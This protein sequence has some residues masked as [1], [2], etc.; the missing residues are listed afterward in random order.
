M[1]LT[2]EALKDILLSYE[3]SEV[4]ELF[5]W[6]CY[7]S[8][9]LYQFYNDKPELEMPAPLMVF[10]ELDNWQGTSQRSG[11]WQYYE[12]RSFEDG[13][14]E[15]VTDYLR[16]L[17]ETELADTYASGIHDYSDPEYTK[18]GNYDYPDEWLADSENIDIWIDERNNDICSLKR[19]IIL[20][21]RN[22]LLALVNDN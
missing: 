9:F 16:N 5:E 19:S 13:V 20:D 11:V 2:F 1:N 12:S 8:E 3:E 10:N 6:E 22:V 14:F 18:D 21:N 17:G 15:K 4:Y 7:I